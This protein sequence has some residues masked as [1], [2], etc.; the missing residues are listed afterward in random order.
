MS[1]PARMPWRFV[2]ALSI[3]VTISY[4]T[5]FYAFA[6]I[7]EPMEQELG[8]SKT[9]LT[10]AFSLALGSSALF[11]VP[12]GRLIDLGHGRAVMTGGSILAAL[13]LGL[14]AL[15]SNYPAFMA[16]WFGLGIAMSAVL[17]EPAFAVLA[18]HLGLLTRRGI[19]VMTL[20]A[21]FASTI[22]IP[23]THLLI[24][25]LGWRTALLLLAALNLG[26]CAVLHGLSIPG[27]AGRV[28]HGHPSH[29]QPLAAN[30]RR[31]LASASFWFFVVTSVLQ[32]MIST[33]I[34]VHL[35]PMLVERGFSLDAAVAAFAVVGPAQVAA[36]FL[37]GFGERALSLKGIGILTMGLNVLAFGLLPFI[38][39]GSWLI[40]LFAAFYGASNGMMTI[41]RALLP[42][43]LFGR[44]DYG[45]IQGMISLPV[46]VAM[47]AT[48]FAFG[49]LWAWWGSYGA[50]VASCFGMALCSFVTFMLNLAVARNSGTH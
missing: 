13:L 2:S 36:R 19:T 44:E 23:L 50:V 15:V 40:V 45:V 47:A 21:G 3:A 16:I 46:R 49:A 6:L 32:G 18:G 29:A 22:F 30:A 38:P 28:G 26:L 12:V 41:V 37:T 34:P 43:E 10:A 7:I 11:S 5:I 4:G 35:I 8:W 42:P 25:A 48:P 33:G 14:W 31:V 9:A 39:A 1:S 24:E 27:A 17:Y 20:V